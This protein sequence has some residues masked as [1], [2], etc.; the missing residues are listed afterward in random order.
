MKICHRIKFM[1]TVS[2]GHDNSRVCLGY[3]VRMEET[4][5]AMWFTF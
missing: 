3:R 2:Y 4:D 5:T 1:V